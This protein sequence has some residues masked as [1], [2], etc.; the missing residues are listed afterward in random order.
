MKLIKLYI[1]LLTCTLFF[2]INN[3]QNGIN[4]KAIVK[5]DLGN[6][7]ANQS[8]DV[9]FIILKGVGQTN[10][11]QETHSSLSDDNGIIIVNIGEGTTADDF[12]ALD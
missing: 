4:Y 9:Q 8:I 6:V 7:V 2:S 11:Y 3:A 12:T 1:S 10:V 5:N